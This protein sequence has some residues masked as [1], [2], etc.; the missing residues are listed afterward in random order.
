M[1]KPSSKWFVYLLECKN[2][3]LYTGITTDLEKRFQKHSLGKGA[4]FTRLNK[5]ARMLGAKPC[6]N[7]SIASKLEYAVKQLTPAKKRAMAAEWSVTKF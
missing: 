5:P 7:R 2:G 4:M 3:R 1:K 6:R